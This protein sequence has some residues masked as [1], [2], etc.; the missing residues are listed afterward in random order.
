MSR[1]DSTPQE[2]ELER[3]E[4]DPTSSPVSLIDS[5][6]QGKVL[7][8]KEVDLSSSTVSLELTSQTREERGGLASSLRLRERGRKGNKHPE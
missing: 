7:E 8:R 5:T 3:K 4:G 6:P 1:I 2:K